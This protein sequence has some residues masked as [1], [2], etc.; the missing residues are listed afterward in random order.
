[1]RTIESI[2]SKF[3]PPAFVGD[4][5]PDLGYG[6]NAVRA[7]LW[8]H[9]GIVTAFVE[10]RDDTTTKPDQMQVAVRLLL[11][12]RE[13]LQ[14]ELAELRYFNPTQRQLQPEID[15]ATM[16]DAAKKALKDQLARIG[17]KWDGESQ[18]VT[19]TPDAQ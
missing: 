7:A 16:S 6:R 19:I 17:A 5:T 4:V 14:K 8:D 3:G 10:M 2:T 1:M 18:H 13:V 9:A 15:P 11:S 12:E